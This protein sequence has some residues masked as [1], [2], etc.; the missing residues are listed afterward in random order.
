MSIVK[1]KLYINGVWDE[2]CTL[3]RF[4]SQLTTFA[5]VNMIIQ[6]HLTAAVVFKT[7]WFFIAVRDSVCFF[8]RMAVRNISELVV[9]FQRLQVGNQYETVICLLHETVLFNRNL[10]H[11]S[12]C[13]K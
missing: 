5:V 13:P 11:M 6:Q 9:C 1:E 2:V 8:C 10:F 12:Y 7:V 4:L 3:G